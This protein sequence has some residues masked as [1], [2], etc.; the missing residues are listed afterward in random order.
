MRYR[1]AA[2][3]PP[4]LVGPPLP[5][6]KTTPVPLADCRIPVPADSTSVFVHFSTEMMLPV[7]SRGDSSAHEQSGS[8]RFLPHDLSTPGRTRVRFATSRNGSHPPA[9]P[10]AARGSYQQ[11]PPARIAPLLA[12]LR[13]PCTPVR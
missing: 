7:R 3:A 5:V 2:L 6:A 8:H 4:I 12:V 1:V 11:A 10:A 13:Q 9:A